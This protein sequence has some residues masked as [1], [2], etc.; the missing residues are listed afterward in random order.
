MERG[1]S[2]LICFFHF[3]SRRRPFHASCVCLP[4]TS[5]CIRTSVDFHDSREDERGSLESCK[6]ERN[7]SLLQ[8][9]GIHESSFSFRC[10]FFCWKSQSRHSLFPSS[11]LSHHFIS[12]DELWW[13]LNR[14]LIFALIFSLPLVG[15]SIKMSLPI[16]SFLSYSAFCLST[17]RPCMSNRISFHLLIHGLAWLAKFRVSYAP[18]YS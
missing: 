6:G 8:C 13:E 17:R 16:S 11:L 1:Y 14:L 2:G 4:L 15:P 18:L 7:R 3:I 9:S 12:R 10:L 5:F